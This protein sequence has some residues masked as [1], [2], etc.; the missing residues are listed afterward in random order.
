MRKIFLRTLLAGI[1][2]SL[3]GIG[4]FRV[5]AAEGPACFF[6]GYQVNVAPPTLSVSTGGIDSLT[7]DVRRC[8]GFQL[9]V[10]NAIV[11]WVSRDPAIATVTATGLKVG[12]T[13]VAPGS[14]YMV[15]TSDGGGADSSLVTVTG[16]CTPTATHICP[17]DDVFSKVNAQ[18]GGT[19]FTFGAGTFYNVT[20]N[21]A[22]EAGMSFTGAANHATIFDGGRVLTGWVLSGNDWGVGG[23]TQGGDQ[24]TSGTCEL[25]PDYP[26][27]YPRCQW[28]EQLWIDSVAMRHVDSRDSVK[29]GT[30]LFDYGTDSIFVGDNPNGRLVETSVTRQFIVAND[31]AITIDGLVIRH[32]ATLGNGLAPIEANGG[33]RWLVQNNWFLDNS[34]VGLRIE[35]DS[36]EVRNNVMK[37]NAQ[38]G[39]TASLAD[40]I[41]FFRNRV[42][43]N[44]VAGWNRGF[45]AGAMKVTNTAHGT[46]EGNRAEYNR[47]NGW[48]WD[49]DNL[50][51]RSISDTSQ[52]NMGTGFFYEI[53]Y[54]PCLIQ[55]G[56]SVGNGTA[57]TDAFQNGAGVLISASRGCEVTG[58]TVTDNKYG[59]LLLQ[60]NRGFGDFGERLVI[61]AF[62]HANT[63][64]MDEGSTGFKGD[65]QR[66]DFNFNRNNRFEDN[67]YFLTG[68]ADY[69][70]HDGNSLTD[71]AW[72]GFGHDSPD[73]SFTRQ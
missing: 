64:T 34:S 14:A 59:I 7:A 15:A 22:I 5:S 37:R 39:F 54:A 6:D 47:G 11:T 60:Q 20:L 30:W 9:G 65:H 68:A 56:I 28:P 10:P 4:Y 16:S 42:D 44:N 69:F 3:I 17:G 29:A 45:G 33:N 48:W 23:Q 12:V 8:E 66:T 26:V 58:M 63:V 70:S 61:D 13:G 43:S 1:V 57:P 32:Y 52:F 67:D 40:S 27:N 19:A 36:A 73:G 50:A 71:A 41:Y 46:F 55:N 53:S 2:W 38:F 35:G 24:A 21:T 18:G 25:A 72:Q 51:I 49:I 62:I 31:H